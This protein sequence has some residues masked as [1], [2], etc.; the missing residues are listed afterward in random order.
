[1]AVFS[2]ATLMERAGGVHPGVHDDLH[3]VQVLPLPGQPDTDGEADQMVQAPVYRS[4]LEN[5]TFMHES[6]FR[7]SNHLLAWFLCL[8]GSE[9][10]VGAI[11]QAALARYCCYLS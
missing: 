8:P 5:N 4:E 2:V 1:M 6:K 9:E 7:S 10:V 3:D 11:L